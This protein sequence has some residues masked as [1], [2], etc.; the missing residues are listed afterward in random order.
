MAGVRSWEATP[1]L[2]L[3]ATKK[4]DTH[5]APPEPAAPPEPPAPAAP[6]S[7]ARFAQ[8]VSG[9]IIR[10]YGNGNE[11]I[12]IGAPSGTPVRAA[13]DG[14]VAAITQDTDQ[15]PI[16]VVRHPDG[17]LTVYAN[18]RNITVARGDRVTGGQT[19]AEV[20]GGSPSFLHFE[21]RR[22]FESVDPNEYLP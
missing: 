12:D 17:L 16:L 1:G 4:D 19:I 2:K 20:G 18:I 7:T 10:P 22:G 21:V 9:N 11:G 15:I 6:A 8:P 14:E 13:G 5:S 3:S